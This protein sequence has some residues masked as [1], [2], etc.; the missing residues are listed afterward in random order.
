MLL[1]K[2]IFCIHCDKLERIWLWKRLSSAARSGQVSQPGTFSEGHFCNS[3]WQN[4]LS[5][6]KTHNPWKQRHLCHL[7]PATF[8]R[9]GA[10]TKHTLWLLSDAQLHSK[11]TRTQCNDFVSIQT[12][13]NSSEATAEHS[14]CD[15]EH[16]ETEGNVLRAYLLSNSTSHCK[17]V[18]LGDH[19]SWKRWNSSLDTWPHIIEHVFYGMH[20]K[21]LSSCVPKHYG[22]NFS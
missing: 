19:L 17:V 7:S 22:I 2:T 21:Y 20:Y 1:L 6:M 18:T 15:S 9:Q 13:A 10:Q 5:S 4:P 3:P 11:R 14:L 16:T 8:F 12:H